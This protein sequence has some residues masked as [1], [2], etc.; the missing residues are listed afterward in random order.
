MSD[1]VLTKEILEAGFREMCKPREP[2]YILAT[3]FSNEELYWLV[4]HTGI[5]V[6]VH[7]DQL[8]YIKRKLIDGEETE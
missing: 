2:S 3:G 1:G 4:T 5:K 7:P 8:D 6:L